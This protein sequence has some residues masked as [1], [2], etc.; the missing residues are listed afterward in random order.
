MVCLLVIH[1]FI[2]STQNNDDCAHQAHSSGAQITVSSSFNRQLN[3]HDFNW[4]PCLTVVVSKLHSHIVHWA[5]D[6]GDARARTS[7]L[8]VHQTIKQQNE[9]IYIVNFVRT[10]KRRVA[11]NNAKLYLY[12]MFGYVLDLKQSNNGTGKDKQI[13]LS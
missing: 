4:P 8:C 3:A 1:S 10:F 2:H 5:P 13:V 12:I 9:Y 7:S 6:V 11:R